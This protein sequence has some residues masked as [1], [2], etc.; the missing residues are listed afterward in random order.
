MSILATGARKVVEICVEINCVSALVKKKK[1]N[2]KLKKTFIDEEENCQ[3]LFSSHLSL[4]VLFH[5]F[6][7]ASPNYIGMC[8]RVCVCVCVCVCVL[9]ILIPVRFFVVCELLFVSICKFFRLSKR[10]QSLMHVFT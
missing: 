2:P 6:S 9:F 1:K 3:L 5:S 10:I 4:L 8:V 7:F